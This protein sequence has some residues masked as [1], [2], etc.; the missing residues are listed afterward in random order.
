MMSFHESSGKFSGSFV[1]KTGSQER[2]FAF[3]RLAK[4]KR[5]GVR[6]WLTRYFL[7]CVFNRNCTR[8]WCLRSFEHR[9]R[10]YF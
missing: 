4:W 9:F 8:L 1:C 3:L 5:K 7:V 2:I 6:M 10:E